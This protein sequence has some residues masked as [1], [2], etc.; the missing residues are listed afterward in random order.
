MFKF[1]KNKVLNEKWTGS[2]PFKSG[3]NCPMA[4]I[5]P[6]PVYWPTA[7]SIKSN[8]IPQIRSMMKYG[9][10]KIPVNTKYKKYLLKLLK[11]FYYI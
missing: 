3:H 9:I 11:I 10:R 5:G 2:L 4:P 8:G 6:R 7:S 1:S